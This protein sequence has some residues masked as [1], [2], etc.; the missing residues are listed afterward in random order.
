MEDKP[1]DDD[2]KRILLSNTLSSQP[3]MDAA[4]HQSITTELTIHGTKAASTSASDHGIILIWLYQIPNCLIVLG[5]KNRTTS[6][7]KSS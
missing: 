4:I 1:V 6:R 7:N 3:D 2:T 5:L